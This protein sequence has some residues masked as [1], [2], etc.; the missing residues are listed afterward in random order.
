MSCEG[1]GAAGARRRHCGGRLC[2]VCRGAPEHRVISEALLRKAV[3][4][5][6]SESYPEPIGS[7]VNCRHPAFRRQRM[8]LW[9]DVALRCLELGVQ[10]PD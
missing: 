9:G 2:A 5:L 4:W 3:P 7:A 8:Y 6:P 10:L 1:C